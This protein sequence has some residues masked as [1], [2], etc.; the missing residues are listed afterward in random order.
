MI[1]SLS[2]S[3][4]IYQQK[5][6]E[7]QKCINHLILGLEDLSKHHSLKQC[8]IMLIDNGGSEKLAANYFELFQNI[9]PKQLSSS[10]N[11]EVS[12]KNLGFGAGH[13]LAIKR[14]NEL[15]KL[16][17]AHLILNADTEIPSLTLLKLIECISQD[18]ISACSAQGYDKHGNKQHLAKRMP[19]PYAL[20]CRA[21]GWKWPKNY[22]QRRLNHYCYADTDLESNINDVILLSG[23]LMMVESSHLLKTG[24]FSDK[25]FLFFEDYDLTLKLKKHGRTVTIPEGFVHHG[26]NT[27]SKKL[28]IRL[29]FI[30]S[31]IK[32]FLSCNANKI[33]VE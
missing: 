20:F 19:T 7:L 24:G 29:Y 16:G 2:I 10:L 9:N 23:C 21:T 13:N 27:R 3:I 1:N 11:I 28:S 5:S 8:H 32:W 14:L 30:S 17:Q 6:D 22:T 15:D 18:D 12:N 26:G 33:E 25:Y 31:A 4:V